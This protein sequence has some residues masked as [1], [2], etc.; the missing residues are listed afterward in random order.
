MNVYTVH[1]RRHALNLDQ[2]LVLVREGFSFWAFLMSLLY[3]LWH[4]MWWVACGLVVIHGFVH[5]MTWAFHIDPFSSTVIGLGVSALLGLFANDLRRWSLERKGFGTF[6][7]VTGRT[8][9]EALSRFL[10]SNP[11]L[12]K[13]IL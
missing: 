9:E 2:D 12:S 5:L 1:M 11:A 10:E 6:G 13:D 4:R 3:V 8:E 7:L